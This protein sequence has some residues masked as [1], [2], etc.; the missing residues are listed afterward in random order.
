MGALQG[1]FRGNPDA[2]V[3]VAKTLLEN[4]LCEGKSGRGQQYFEEDKKE[5][6]I[7][8]KQDCYLIAVK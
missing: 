8:L 5:F 4:V 2:T 3:P 7:V 1:F 6:S